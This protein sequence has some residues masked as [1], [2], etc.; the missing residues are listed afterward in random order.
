METFILPL[1]HDFY[2]ISSF[3]FLSIY[4]SI[5]V[6]CQKVQVKRM[7]EEEKEVNVRS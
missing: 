2:L 5:Y 6:W 1:K 3:V 7:M 4:E